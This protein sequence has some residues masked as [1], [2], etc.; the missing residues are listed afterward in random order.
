MKRVKTV[1]I[2]ALVGLVVLAHAGLWTSE[3]WTAEAKLRLTVL[4][5]LGWAVVVLPALAVRR[6]A[7]AHR[8]PDATSAGPDATPP[9]NGSP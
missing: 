5:A 1:A 2:V 6:W 4:N 9:R 8:D 7:A 3:M